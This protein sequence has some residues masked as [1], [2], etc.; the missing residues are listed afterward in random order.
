M[1]CK[2]LL[3][4][5]LDATMELST[6][7]VDCPNWRAGYMTAHDAAITLIK[8]NCRNCEEECK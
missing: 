7:N 8:K 1:K 5:S 6:E 3:L 2:E 4:I